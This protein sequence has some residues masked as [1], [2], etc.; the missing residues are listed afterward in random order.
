MLGVTGLQSCV[1]QAAPWPVPGT[2]HGH[3]ALRLLELA[4]QSADVS[5]YCRSKLSDQVVR[6]MKAGD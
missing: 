2:E 1:G 6:I 5:Y 4:K 3:E